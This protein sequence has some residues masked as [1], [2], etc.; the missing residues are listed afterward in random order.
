MPESVRFNSSTDS[1]THQRH[2]MVE[3]QIRRRGIHNQR[4][5]NAIS[6]VPRHKFVSLEYWAQAYNDHPIPIGEGQTIS[7]PYIVAITLDALSVTSSDVVL[8]I[9]T[10]SGYQ[11]ALLAELCKHVYSIE[12]HESLA[13]KAK[14]TLADLGYRNITVIIG[15]GTQGL[16]QYAPFEAVAV[17]AAA[18]ELPANLFS[19]LRE[20]GN[21]VI[22]IGVPEV[23]QLQLIRKQGG[24]SLVTVLEG[25][26][27]VPLIGAQG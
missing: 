23:Q 10:G 7:Q 8:E 2:A 3:Y 4:I 16:P 15:D 26:R 5:L 11:T 6:R 19:Q 27:F 13:E 9:G 18:S 1:F 17:A 25:C 14:R 12:L 21:L 24:V 22:P 20:G